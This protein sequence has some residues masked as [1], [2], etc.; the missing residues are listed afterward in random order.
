M[1]NKNLFIYSMRSVIIAILILLFAFKGY[2]QESKR[3]LKFKNKH[4]YSRGYII[5]IDSSRIEGLVKD[6]HGNE[7]LEQSSVVFVAESGKKSRYY[8]H[9]IQGYGNPVN[10]FASDGG[11]FYK[12]VQSGRKVELYKLNSSN[13]WSAPAAGPGMPAMN[14]HTESETFYVRKVNERRFRMVKKRKFEE[15]FAEYFKDCEAVKSK[16]LNKELT[17]KDIKRLVQEYNLCR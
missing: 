10:H 12:R 4:N 14:Y 9:E 8:P 6:R 11:S 5:S 3:Y 17:H 16:I 7:R 13:N 2:G 1:Y 15:V